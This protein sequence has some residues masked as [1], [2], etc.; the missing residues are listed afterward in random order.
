MK[1]L[2]SVKDKVKRIRKQARNWEKIFAKGFLQIKIKN[3]S[4][5]EL[6][7]NNKEINNPIKK[8]VKDF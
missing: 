7:L 4:H 3:Y 1:N 8:W 2:C 6:K 5:K